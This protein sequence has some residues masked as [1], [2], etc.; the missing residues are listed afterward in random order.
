[1]SIHI[2]APRPTDVCC[3]IIDCPTCERP[4]RAIAKFYEWY[5][6]SVACAGCGDRWNDGEMEER[7]FMPGWR[8]VGREYAR[9]ELAKIGVQA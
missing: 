4:R 9:R 6:A 7:P 5:G 8:K 3:V 1:M 2:N